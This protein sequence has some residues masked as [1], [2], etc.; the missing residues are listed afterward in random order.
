MTNAE[1]LDLIRRFFTKEWKKLSE[2]DIKLF[3]LQAGMCNSVYIV[4]RNVAPETSVPALLEP[5]KVVIRKFG[6]NAAEEC[7]EIPSTPREAETLVLREAAKLGI[8]PQVYG[9]FE[10]GRLE[11]FVASRHL[12]TRDMKEDPVLRREVA[13]TLAKFHSMD[14]PLPK[15]L[16]EG[17]DVVRALQVGWD[18]VKDKYLFDEGVVRNK[19]DAKRIV[20]FDFA[21]DVNWLEK[22]YADEH[23]RM[24][25]QHW[26]TQYSNILVR[27]D[28][29]EKDDRSRVFLIDDELV[30]YN[31]RGKDTGLLFSQQVVDFQNRADKINPFPS[32]EECCLFLKEYQDEV[33]RLGFIEDFDPNGKDSL[34]HLYMESLIGGMGSALIFLLYFLEYHHLYTH[35]NDIVIVNTERIFDWYLHVK[36]VFVNRFPRM[37]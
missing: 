26:D 20:D 14:L 28:I 21:S 4:E 22:L 25:L 6:G 13:V 33:E 18:K 7:S 8:G 3:R 11:E 9:V 10:G 12:T 16:Y 17:I 35:T 15:P 30:S 29:P 5:V 27:Q 19:V 37:V 2:D 1:A 23:H 32:E 36:A 24:V 34:E 31:I